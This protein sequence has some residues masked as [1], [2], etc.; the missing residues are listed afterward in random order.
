M[1]YGDSMTILDKKTPTIE[2]LSKK[3]KVDISEI[4]KELN[5]GIKVELEHTSNKKVAEEIALDHLSERLDYYRMLQKME[6]TADMN[7]RDKDA[8]EGRGH[9]LIDEFSIGN[10][11]LFLIE[12]P[13]H[14]EYTQVCGSKYQLAFNKE[15][16]GMQTSFTQDAREFRQ[17]QKK[18]LEKNK[19]TV[20]VIPARELCDAIIRW[21]Q[22][23]GPL[24]VGGG[25]AEIVKKYERILL[26]K[27]M[28][29]N[30]NIRIT[31]HKNMLRTWF[32]ISL[33]E[34]SSKNASTHRKIAKKKTPNS[35]KGKLRIK[36][37]NDIVKR[38][39]LGLE[40]PL[41]LKTYKF[42]SIGEVLEF[43]IKS[44]SWNENEV[45]KLLEQ[46][47]H[48]LQI[49]LKKINQVLPNEPVLLPCEAVINLLSSMI[50]S[51]ESVD[52]DIVLQETFDT[53]LQPLRE[54][55]E[56]S[57]VEYV[58][59]TPM[60][61]KVLLNQSQRQLSNQDVQELSTRVQNTLSNPAP[62]QRNIRQ[63]VPTLEDY[64]NLPQIS[65]SRQVQNVPRP[66]SELRTRPEQ[67]E[68]ETVN[69][70]VQQ[71]NAVE[72]ENVIKILVT[73]PN[74]YEA[75]VTFI[76]PHKRGKEGNSIIL[77]K[78]DEIVNQLNLSPK[79]KE[80]FL[81]LNYFMPIVK[82]YNTFI[83]AIPYISSRIGMQVRI[84]PEH[85][86]SVLQRI[87]SMGDVPYINMTQ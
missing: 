43:I 40:V 26:K 2:Q 41:N 83:S 19:E 65:P 18:V 13:K 16:E 37:A 34:P 82:G 52:T 14:S 39:N 64:S 63:N 50:R 28:Q 67:K 80:C 85:N 59:L 27:L 55:F 29:T 62:L 42:V 57:G 66:P 1:K 53:R 46:V 86:N 69:F 71:F 44:Q 36:I 77:Q 10:Y 17:K 47:H 12:E 11:H 33:Q 23:Y 79:E 81:D 58:H 61:N 6:K 4:T 70:Q 48:R 78:M 25:S 45:K 3:Y 15:I 87:V 68:S 21:V 7:K 60:I 38:Q 35:I 49:M 75:F 72:L 24:M 51:E 76:N 56:L 30:S 20:P 54:K 22:T 31:S 84:S 9:K 8:I 5:K 73:D 74:V 32:M